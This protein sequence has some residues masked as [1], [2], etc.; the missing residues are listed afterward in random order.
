[1]WAA[2]GGIIGALGFTHLQ[3][4]VRKMLRTIG[5]MQKWYARQWWTV[6]CV[7]PHQNKKYNIVLTFDKVGCP[8]WS[9]V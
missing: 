3:V 5:N 4:P 9:S 2:Y 6:I 7:S 8:L 1:M